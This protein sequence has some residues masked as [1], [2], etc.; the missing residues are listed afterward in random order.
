M[1]DVYLG[2]GCTT[3]IGSSRALTQVQVGAG[4]IHHRRRRELDRDLGGI[5]A[6][7]RAKRVSNC[8]MQEKKTD[9]LSVLT[10]G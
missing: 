6:F 3:R 4:A 8:Y 9:R 2:E 7:I 10:F 5:M 1:G